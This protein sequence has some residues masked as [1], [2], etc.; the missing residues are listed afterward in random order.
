MNR[1]Q[2]AFK[3]RKTVIPFI[4]AG[5]PDIATTA[6]L[7]CRMDNAGAD[8]IILGLPFSD[9]VAADPV[10]QTSYERALKNGMSADG[11]FDCVEQ[12]RIDSNVP[13]VVMAYMNTIF[14]YGIDR[15]L[16]NAA[17][18]GIAAIIVP[19]VPYEE[20]SVLNDACNQNDIALI[21]VIVPCSAERISM[22]CSDAKGFIYC[23]SSPNFDDAELSNAIQTARTCSNLPC[24]L[25]NNI[26]TPEQ[27]S[28]AANL[29]D[30]IVI[31]STVVRLLERHGK[32]TSA[33]IDDF[34]NRINSAIHQH[35]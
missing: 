25:D 27:A 33:H 11:L 4:T 32:E 15:F 16:A 1:L 20:K 5:D 34:I 7:I 14:V 35:G 10:M 21:T 28:S 12:I 8:I 22:L 31:G 23:M 6:Q 30:G 9:P 24:V 17:R 3:N 13:L 2:S 19:D 26:H 18:V 29:A